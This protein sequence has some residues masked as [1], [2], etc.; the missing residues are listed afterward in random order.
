[1]PDKKI[2]WIWL[3]LARFL[4][5]E[6]RN[7]R[8]AKFNGATPEWQ[9]R[10]PTSRAGRGLVSGNFLGLQGAINPNIPQLNGTSSMCVPDQVAGFDPSRS[11]TK[12]ADNLF[13]RFLK[14]MAERQFHEVTPR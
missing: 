13:D 2:N 8:P 3:N 11:W 4:P 12:L 10:C 9:N 1:M 5:I 14:L 6:C 7:H